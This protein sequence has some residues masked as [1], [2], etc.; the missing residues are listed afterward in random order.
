MAAPRARAASAFSMTSA[1]A[2]SPMTKPSRFFAKGLAAA[3]GGSLWVDSAESR[4]KR[5]SASA[6]TEPS[7]PMHRAASVSPRRIAST[8]SWIAVAPEEHAVD[9]EIGEPL[10]PKRSAIRSATVPNRKRSC[11]GLKRPVAAAPQKI[12]VGDAVVLSRGLGERL[13]LRPFELDR[14]HR[15]E[16]GA[17]EVAGPAGAGLADRLLGGE[18]RQTL[19]E[20][21]RA[22]RLGRDEVDGAGNRRPQRLGREAVDGVNARAAGGERRPVVL[23]P[24]P[25]RGDDPRPVTATSG[26]P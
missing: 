13:A 1:A 12:P 15:D 26:R 4:E 14:R 23:P 3:S 20:H 22:E 17:R 18:H 7:V 10:V 21:R 2:P 6:C 19:G 9:S 5:I 16:Q 24:L 25:E 11:Q 8:P